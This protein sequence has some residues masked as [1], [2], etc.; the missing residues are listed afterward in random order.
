[1][2]PLDVGD[3]F[4][5]FISNSNGVRGFYHDTDVGVGSPK[6]LDNISMIIMF[7]ITYQCSSLVVWNIMEPKLYCFQIS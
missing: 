4:I 6:V 1:L 7:T 2:V 3:K 5:I